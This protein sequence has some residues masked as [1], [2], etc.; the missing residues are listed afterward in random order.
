MLCPGNTFHNSRWTLSKV[1]SAVAGQM[2]GCDLRTVA[3][4]E[5]VDLCRRVFGATEGPVA[6][7]LLRDGTERE[8]HMVVESAEKD[9]GMGSLANWFSVRLTS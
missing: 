1:E 4:D 3:S 5:P 9:S 7:R 8:F 2:N 6:D